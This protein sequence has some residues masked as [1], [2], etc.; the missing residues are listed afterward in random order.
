MNPIS[1]SIGMVTT[2]LISR[3]GG[4]LQIDSGYEKDYPI[5]RGALEQLGIAIESI[6]CLV[7]TRNFF[8]QDF[9]GCF[10]KK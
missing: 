4:Y 6:K 10:P 2:Y 5:Y 9:N 7:L 8:Y 3:A 1:I